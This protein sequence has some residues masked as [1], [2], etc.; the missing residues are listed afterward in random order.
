MRLHLEREEK[1]RAEQAAER[2]ETL[3]R[4]EAE[5]SLFER[6]AGKVA[7]LPAH[8]RVHHLPEPPAPIPVQRQLDD[9]RVLKEAISDEFDASTLLEVDD[10]LSFRRP[11]IGIDVARKLRRGH[12]SIQ[13]EIDLHG[14]RREEAREALA[15]FLRNAVRDGLRCVRVVHGKGLGSPGKTPVLKGKVHSWLIQKEQV[16]AFVQARG[17]EGGAGAVVVLLKPSP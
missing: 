17:D 13:S 15:E 3:R 5:R 8:G 6:A 7:R 10:A 12:W 2:A 4:L 1:R 14:L 9:Q 16:L 11:G